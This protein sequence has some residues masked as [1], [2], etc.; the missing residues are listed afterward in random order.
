MKLREELVSRQEKGEL[1][2]SSFGN[3]SIYTA[4]FRHR[5]KWIEEKKLPA[6][7]DHTQ[8]GLLSP[9]GNLV[10][11]ALRNYGNQKFRDRLG[12][13]RQTD[14]RIVEF[15]DL[16][17][18]ACWSSD[19]QR[20][21]VWKHSS[22]K[23]VQPILLDL[24]SANEEEL[25]VPARAQFTTQCWSPDGQQL[26][27]HVLDHE[28]PAWTPKNS[29][30]KEP[31]N[32]G[33]VFIYDIGEKKARSLGHG[34]DA[35]WSPDGQWIAFWNDAAEWRSRPSGE[36]RQRLFD[37]RKA[38]S[39]LLWSPDSELVLYF[40][41]CYLFSSLQCMCDVGGW[42]VRRLPDH[43]EVEVG[44]ESPFGYQNVWIKNRLR[45]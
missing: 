9:D 4:D 43:A 25:N 45:P 37:R 22:P 40:R 6:P 29:R 27:Y 7:A 20:L 11:L 16:E 35:T 24:N 28:P 32:P 3:G 15:S 18:A 39:P 38:E 26:V 36:E 13:M 1:A 5:D 23:T 12:V 21:I 19:S 33:T 44:K 14:G 42:F 31:P 30:R 41:C 2:L 10:A 34:E 8:D 17:S